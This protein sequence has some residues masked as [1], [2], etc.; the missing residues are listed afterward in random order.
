[1]AS[2]CFKTKKVSMNMRFKKLVLLPL[3]SLTL[4]GTISCTN[5]EATPSVSN[6]VYEVTLNVADKC[7]VQRIDDTSG[8]VATYSNGWTFKQYGNACFELTK[9]SNKVVYSN[10]RYGYTISIY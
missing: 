10:S 9:E 7:I 3:I 8:I 2:F 5:K 6:V 4:L 1:M